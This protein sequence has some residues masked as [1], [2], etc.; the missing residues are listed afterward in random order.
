MPG[1]RYK[2]SWDVT[3]LDP[4][5]VKVWLLGGTG[6]LQANKAIWQVQLSVESFGLS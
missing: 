2:S 5:V 4:D 1:C 6:V 3:P